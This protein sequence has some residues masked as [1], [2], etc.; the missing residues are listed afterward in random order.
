VHLQLIH[1]DPKLENFIGDADGSAC[2]LLDLDTVRLGLV[3]HDLGDCLRSACNSV[4][5]EGD[6]EPVF[7]EAACR[8]ILSGYFSIADMAWSISQR[9]LIYDGVLLIC[10]ELGMRFFTDYLSGNTY[11]KVSDH[12]Q[13]LRRAVRQ[14][15]LV[16]LLLRDEK[17]L[18]ELMLEASCQE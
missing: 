14:L 1:G 15:Q 2:G 5:E 3:H 10:F 8:E 12:Q 11:F 9:E 17:R 4:G 18:R 6:S 16:T 13:N 7:D